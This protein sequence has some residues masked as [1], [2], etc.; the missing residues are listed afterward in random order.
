MSSTLP[1]PRIDLYSDTK[2]KPS[3]GMRKA[4]ANAGPFKMLVLQLRSES[5]RVKMLAVAVMAKMSGDT[6]DNVAEIAKANG[7]G[8]GWRNRCSSKPFLLQEES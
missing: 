6:E 2:S 3:P 4:I 5:A 8:R 1:P 7:R